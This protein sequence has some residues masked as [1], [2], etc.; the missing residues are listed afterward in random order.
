MP[1]Q[2]MREEIVQWLRIG[3][4]QCPYV[5]QRPHYI[6]QLIIRSG[7]IN[8]PILRKHC[9]CSHSPAWS[10]PVKHRLRSVVC[11][12][13]SPIGVTLAVE[14]GQVSTVSAIP[15]SVRL[16]AL[17]FISKEIR[18]LDDRVEI[19]SPSGRVSERAYPGSGA[20]SALRAVVGP[21]V[22]HSRLS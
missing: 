16:T 11:M 6:G 8:S 18:P 19:R 7:A 13:D 20:M 2:N 10:Q 5:K 1:E 14:I 12:L 3:N 9:V 22:H 17:G 15:V 21:R 4:R